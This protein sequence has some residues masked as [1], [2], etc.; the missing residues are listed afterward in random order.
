[1]RRRFSFWWQR[2]I[3]AEVRGAISSASRLPGSE[4]RAPA[5]NRALEGS[6]NMERDH[7]KGLKDF[8]KF[9][10]TGVRHR[11]SDAEGHCFELEGSIDPILEKNFDEMAQGIGP[12]WCWLLFDP[13]GSLCV[14]LDSFA[15]EKGSAI[16]TCEASAEPPDQG[17]EL[18][19]LSSYW[20]AFHV[21]M[22]LDPGW[23]WRREQFRASD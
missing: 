3:R 2:A 7:P 17:M 23:G 6:R 4:G 12:Q 9:L 8:P 19:F 11:R 1:M 15:K 10:V 14:T 20:Q 13:R 16:F 21:W 5:R 22:V 18:A